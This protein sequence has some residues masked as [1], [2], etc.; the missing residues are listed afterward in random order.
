MTDAL[1]NQNGTAEPDLNS[2]LVFRDRSSEEDRSLTARVRSAAIW[3]VASSLGLRLANI[4]LT[5]VIAHI[6]DP[7]AFG[8]FAVALTAYAIVSAI[9]ELGVSACLI[10]ADLDIDALAPTM[11][12]VSIATSLML[13]A[14]MAA[15]A[16]PISTVLGARNG[17]AAEPIRVMALAVIMVGLFAVPSSQLVRDFK[18][19]KLFLSNVVSFFPSTAVLVLLAKHAAA[20]PVPGI[21]QQAALA[22]QVILAHGGAMA[23]AWSRVVGQGVAGA[24]VVAS[25]NRQYL[26]GLA[27]QA[28]SLLGRFGLPLAAA[29]F[30]GYVLLNV[31]YAFIGHLLAK[32]VQGEALLGTYVLAFNVAS[33]PSTLLNSMISNVSMPAFTRVTHDK[34]LFRNAIAGSLGWLAWAVMPACAILMALAS[35]IVLTLYGHQ[36]AGAATPLSLL[37]L[38]C[39]VSVIC[40]FFGN[41]VA[42]VGKT[43]ALLVIQLIWLAALVPAMFIGVT[44]DGIVGAAVAHIV[45]IGPI[46][47]PSYL[48][49]LKRSTGTSITSLGRAMLPTVLAA[50]LAGLAANRATVLFHN[51]LA[52]L[53]VGGAAGG[54]TYLLLTAPLAIARLPAGRQGH[55][56][57]RAVLRCYQIPARLVGIRVYG[58]PRHSGRAGAQVAGPERQRLDAERE[59]LAL[60]KR[61]EAGLALL[62]SLSTLAEPTDASRGMLRAP[63][64]ASLDTALENTVELLAVRGAW[65]VRPERPER[66]ERAGG[67]RGRRDDH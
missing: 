4:A 5:A 8:T 1:T 12:T 53:I 28:L 33:W 21:G 15:F 62:V 64:R 24:V 38:Y 17:G 36:Y 40:L 3:S 46:V 22:H 20:T 29:N 41:I 44:R 42:S 55:R 6:I 10:R 56:L 47:L 30:V 63:Y 35:P 50:I 45:V 23:F 26:P 16:R 27:R 54:L 11:A 49:V 31:D 37:T 66:A 13:G 60:R 51:S 48:Y 7:A 2:I 19:N 67:R 59:A 18:Q 34:E 58:A 65:A 43:R 9:G 14:A 32:N 25:V 52:Q 39:L 57:V 61:Q